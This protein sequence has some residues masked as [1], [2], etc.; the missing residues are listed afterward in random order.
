MK[1]KIYININIPSTNNIKLMRYSVK[2][3]HQTVK[4]QE[5]QLINNENNLLKQTQIKDTRVIRGC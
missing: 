5:I 4:R 2:S 3:Y 1:H